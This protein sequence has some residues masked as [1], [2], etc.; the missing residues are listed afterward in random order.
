MLGSMLGMLAFSQT[1]EIGTE[2]RNQNYGEVIY[3]YVNC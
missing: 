3:F 2:L 1:V